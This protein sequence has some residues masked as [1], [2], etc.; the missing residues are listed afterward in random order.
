VH[1]VVAGE[2]RVF[3]G[4][5]AP[6]GGTWKEAMLRELG[7]MDLSR[8]HF[9]G[10]LGY[11]GYRDLLR[12]SS[13]HVYLTVPFVLSWSLLEA[14]A[15]GCAIVASDTAPVRE[16]I[17]DGAEGSLVDFFSIDAIAG[18]VDRKLA[19]GARAAA[20][21]RTARATALAQFALARLLPRQLEMVR[22]LAGKG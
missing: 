2:D 3:Y 5:P 22:E 10:S 13:V 14:M 8:I 17:T 4:G 20:L 15:S 9:V 6:G 12:A 7:G 21:R 1:V 16:F 18:Q 19:D 11:V